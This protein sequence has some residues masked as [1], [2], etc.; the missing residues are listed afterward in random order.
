MPRL[1]VAMNDDTLYGHGDTSGPLSP[2]SMPWTMATIV[3]TS[4]SAQAAVF[5]PVL[6]IAGR[7]M[8]LLVDRMRS[9]DVE[10]IV[11]D[12]VHCLEQDEL[13]EVEHAV[14]RYLGL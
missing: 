12:P 4:T 3:P 7:T 10:Y 11:G 6:E 2:T 1:T 13:A 8:H 14:S 9:V 5:R